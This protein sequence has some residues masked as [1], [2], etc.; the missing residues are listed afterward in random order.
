MK[1]FKWIK[2]RQ[3]VH[4]KKMCLLN[5][6]IFRFGMDCYIL[7]YDKNVHLPIHK[8]PLENGSHYRINIK[9]KGSCR[10]WCTRMIY[11]RGEWLNIFRP[12][13]FY[14]SLQTYTPTTKLSIG[15]AWF[16]L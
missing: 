2:G 13:L 1:L 12:D 5:I 7:K 16:N 9:L 11:N 4:Y 6:R 3:N 8:D 10:F 15:I 14:H